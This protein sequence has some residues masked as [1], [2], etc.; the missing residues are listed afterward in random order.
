MEQV[1]VVLQSKKKSTSVFN[2]SILKNATIA[3]SANVKI[4]GVVCSLI[5]ID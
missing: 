2:V 5:S 1:N 4:G 3:P